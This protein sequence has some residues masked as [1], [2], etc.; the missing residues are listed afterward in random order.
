MRHLATASLSMMVLLIPV[1]AWAQPDIKHSTITSERLVDAGKDPSNWLL[2]SGQYNSQ[3]FSQLKQIH[4]GNVE[5]LRV[6]WVR[7]FPITE[8]FETTPLVV[9][10]VM[11]LTLPENIVWALDAKTGLPF[12]SYEHPLPDQLSL[13][14]GKINRGVAILGDTLYMGTL[15]AELVA[16]DSKSGN[17]R[18]T[19]PVADGT[20]GFSLTGAPLIVK[21]MVIV[22]VGGGEYGIRGFVDAYDANTGKRRWRQH[23]IPGPGE[24]GHETWEGDS[25]KV[26]GA[27]T[28]M[29]GSYDPELDLLYWGIGNPGP[30]WNG[31]VRIGDNLYSDCVL[32]FDTDT[33]TIKWHFQFTP[34]DVHD[35]DACQVPVLVDLPYQGKMRKLMLWG[36]RNAFYYVLDRVTGEFLHATAF[37]KQTWAEKIDH[38]GRPV[39]IPDTFPTKDGT[40]VYPDVGGAANWWS[41]TYS[42]KTELFYLMAF[43]GAG[44]YYL[45]AEVDHKP[46]LPFLGGFGTTNEFEEFP[47][48][49]YVS[50]VRALDPTTG[51]RKWEYRVQAK[52][53]S[54]LVSTAGN[55]VFGGTVKGNFF[56]LDSRNG[57]EL[58]RLDLG[59]RVHAAPMTYMVDG[60]QYVTIAVGSALFTLG[61]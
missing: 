29:T 41:P 51:N 22:G 60:K 32:A 13:C 12:W 39:R 15:N 57:T 53:T 11:Y 26:G 48:S 4:D 2:Y 20:Q 21:D 9:D 35:W 18:W 5:D 54:G 37:A 50:A 33:G 31:D 10:G 58:W 7:Q 59:G 46:G 38:T 55:L 40:L 6:K 24:K 42:P 3:R 45:G 28:W 43:D 17:V 34:H 47:D 44:T 27:S 52:S 61:L 8:L 36:N 49:E 14:C 25:W 30:D 23:V 19:V 16:L 1:A 56:A